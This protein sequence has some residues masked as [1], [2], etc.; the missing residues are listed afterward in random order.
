ML[1][2]VGRQAPCVVVQLSRDILNR[3]PT[4]VLVSAPYISWLSKRSCLPFHEMSRS[5]DVPSDVIHM[6]QTNFSSLHITGLRLLMHHTLHHTYSQQ[7]NLC[8]SPTAPGVQTCALQV[9][10]SHPPTFNS[11]RCVQS[12]V[13]MIAA[14]HSTENQL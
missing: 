8:F 2:V 7:L 6:L 11:F 1:E 14:R 10:C 12:I 5:R 3:F 9:A 13:S 4:K